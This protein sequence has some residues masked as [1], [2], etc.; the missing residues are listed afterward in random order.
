VISLKNGGPE[1]SGSGPLSTGRLIAGV[2]L[3]AHDDSDKER[4][5]I[6]PSAQAENEKQSQRRFI[7]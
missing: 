4:I 1:S 5:R 7:K 6:K 3:G 2:V